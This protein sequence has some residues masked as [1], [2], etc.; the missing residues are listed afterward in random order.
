MRRFVCSFAKQIMIEMKYIITSQLLNQ[1]SEDVRQILLQAETLKSM[2]A[3]QLLNRPDPEAWSIAQ[4]LQHMNV[5]SDYYLSAMEIALG[6]NIPPSSSNFKPG[7]LGNYFTNIMGLNKEGNV[8]K[9][10]K[11]PKNAIPHEFPDA[12]IELQNFI[13]HQHLLLNIIKIACNTDL[14]K[15]RIPISIAKFI[16]LKLGDVLMFFVAHEK[17]HMAQ[18]EKIKIRQPKR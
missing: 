1:L 18:I 4:S 15:Q 11:S 6:K 2:N 10:M 12:Q 13:Q 16:K 14:E 8:Q 3:L 5:Y 17:R 9:K 7:I